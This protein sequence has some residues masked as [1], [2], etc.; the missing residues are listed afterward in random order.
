MGVS[1]ISA[2]TKAMLDDDASVENVLMSVRG[3]SAAGLGAGTYSHDAADAL[4]ALGVCRSTIA[5]RFCDN[6]GTLQRP[7]R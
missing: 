1:P 6:S 7:G 4:A 3:S 5:P 2:W